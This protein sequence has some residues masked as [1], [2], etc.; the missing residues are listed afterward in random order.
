MAAVCQSLLFRQAVG[1]F[2]ASGRCVALIGKLMV[3]ALWQPCVS[4]L[5]VLANTRCS[6]GYR[7]G[8]V[9]LGGKLMVCAQWQPCDIVCCA[10][11][12][13]LG[14]LF[15]YRIG[16]VALFGKPP[17]RFRLRCDFALLFSAS[18]RCAFGT[19]VIVRCSVASYRR[20]FLRPVCRCIALWQATGARCGSRCY[21]ALLFLA[22]YRR[23][24]LRPVLWCMLAW[25]DTVAR[26]RAVY[27]RCMLWQAVALCFVGSRDMGC[28]APLQ[29]H[30]ACLAASQCGW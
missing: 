15:G 10:W 30:A 17:V 27:V 5:R 11:W 3:C 22:S 18:H 4:A 25:Q 20:A 9:A 14:A 1:A 23:A 28:Y 24:L 6:F 26:W 2:M 7:F 12:Q 8:C 29:S 19:G 13:T 16:C 21:S